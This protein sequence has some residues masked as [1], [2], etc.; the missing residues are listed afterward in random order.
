M[1]K[2]SDREIM[3]TGLAIFLLYFSLQSIGLLPDFNAA[4]LG[5]Y[6]GAVFYLP[7]MLAG[8]VAGR[9]MEK[10][11]KYV[12]PL[13]LLS[14][15]LLLITPPYKLMVSPSF[16]VLSVLV[17]ILMFQFAKGFDNGVL[18]YL[19]KDPIRYWVLMFVVL[20]V[21]IL[22]YAEKTDEVLPLELDWPVAA[23]LTIAGMVL[24]YVV[25]KVLDVLIGTLGKIE[26]TRD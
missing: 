25:S 4:Y 6:G 14:L 17:S 5:G 15:V 26:I 20:G 11:D 1:I 2:F 9:N 19:G 23:G 16:M 3:F 22:I 18:Q 24:L 8:V 21:P 7:V 10:I 12:F 13:M